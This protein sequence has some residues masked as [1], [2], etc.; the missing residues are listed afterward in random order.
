MALVDSII[1]AESGGN[2]NAANPNSSAS[3]PGQFL[4]R[5]FLDVAR[6]MRPELA[7]QPDSAVLALKTD[8]D[9]ARQ[10]TDYYAQ[11][12]Q[13]TLAKNGLPVTPGNTYLAH[14][15]GPG[16]AVK[17]LQADPNTPVGDI[18]GPKVVAANPF[19]QG[20]T[21]QGLQ[22][23]AAK[24]MGASLPQ[25]AGVQ[26][27]TPASP[28][29]PP[30]GLLQQPPAAGL[31]AGQQAPIFPQGLQAP[32]QQAAPSPVAQVPDMQAAPIFYPQRRP[33]N[34]SAL[35]SAF[36]APVFPRQG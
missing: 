24:K 30:A 9:F 15:A 1:G 7:D 36:Q 28:A 4:D 11:Q 6:Q 22:A 5:T 23:W 19:L 3:G 21:A 13:A 12:N 14:F 18:L 2:P 35:R 8:P 16:G 27:A 34:L 29:S 33:I 17:V 32:Q 10:A 31:L 20:M 25:Q 26:N